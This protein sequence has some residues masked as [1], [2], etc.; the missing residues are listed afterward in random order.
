[1]INTAQSLTWVLHDLTFINL[2]E[3]LKRKSLEMK[4]PK[5]ILKQCLVGGQHA[6]LSM[7]SLRMKY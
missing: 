2:S 5:Y 7:L 3:G 4:G 6:N 1:M